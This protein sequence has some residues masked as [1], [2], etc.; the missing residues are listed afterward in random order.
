M[1]DLSK[2]LRK[3]ITKEINVGN[4]HDWILFNYDKTKKPFLFVPIN[5]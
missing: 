2:I 4:H 1:V 3:R 5:V